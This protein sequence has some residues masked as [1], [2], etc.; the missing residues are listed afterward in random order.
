MTDNITIAF[1]DAFTAK[2]KAVLTKTFESNVESLGIALEK[3]HV[4]FDK[5]NP[6]NQKVLGMMNRVSDNVFS[7][8][9]NEINEL[10][11]SIFATGHETIHIRQYLHGLLRDNEF[12][13]FWKNKFIPALYCVLPLFYTALPWEIEAHGLDQ[14][15]YEKALVK[16]TPEEKDER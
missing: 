1:S 15:I 4:T 12:G 6:A 9:L 11:E 8:K 2:E 14:R 13:C 3:F 7:F 10:Q 5:M 16:L